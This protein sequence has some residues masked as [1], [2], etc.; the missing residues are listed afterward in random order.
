MIV[1]WLCRANWISLG[2]R[3]E[4]G[5]CNEKVTKFKSTKPSHLLRRGTI[6]IRRYEGIWY[7]HET[8][9]SESLVREP[10]HLRAFVKSD[11][12]RPS[13]KSWFVDS[14]GHCVLWTRRTVSPWLRPTAHNKINSVGRWGWNW[15]EGTTDNCLLTFPPVLWAGWDNFLVTIYKAA[16]ATKPLLMDLYDLLV[17]ILCAE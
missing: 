14:S 15:Y 5:E 8:P 16:H 4:P 17:L 13:S 6:Q 12:T 3:D 2:G 7:P 9:P 1:G 11:T 10:S